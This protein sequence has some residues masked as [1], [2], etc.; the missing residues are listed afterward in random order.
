M[1]LQTI[2]ERSD[3]TVTHY[4]RLDHSQVVVG[5]HSSSGQTDN[6]SACSYDEFLNGR[7]HTHIITYF[8]QKVLS[9]VIDSVNAAESYAPF[10]AKREERHAANTLLGHIPMDDTLAELV[11]ASDTEKGFRNYGN[12]GGYKTI[13]RSDTVT[14]TVERNKGFVMSN[15][16][17]EPYPFTLPGHA[18]SVVALRDH[19]YLV[20]SDDYAVITPQGVV[21][22]NELSL[23][24]SFLRINA[25]FRYADTICYGYYWFRG[26]APRGWLRYELGVGFNGHCTQ[27]L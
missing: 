17:G 13:L 8:D 18:S 25:V 16:G 9:D 1:S 4:I 20:V 23:F 12:A 7:F 26:D 21:L 15:D 2:W 10:V 14:L 3:N 22:E 27:T 19:F 11:N 24:G 6:A 5:S